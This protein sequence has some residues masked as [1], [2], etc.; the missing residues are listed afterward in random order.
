MLL[1]LSRAVL[2]IEKEEN[3]PGRRLVPRQIRLRYREHPNDQLLCPA[4]R[5]TG[6]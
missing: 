5:L 4:E 2:L 1:R 6:G 3:G